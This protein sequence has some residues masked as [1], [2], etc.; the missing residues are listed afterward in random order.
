MS[1]N[2]EPSEEYDGDEGDATNDTTS[3]C[4]CVYFIM[5]SA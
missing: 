3:D 1:S 2:E 5:N 4:A